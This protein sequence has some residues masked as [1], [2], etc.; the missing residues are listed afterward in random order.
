MEG[1]PSVPGFNSTPLIKTLVWLLSVPLI[2]ID[3]V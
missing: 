3:F 1:T 2:N